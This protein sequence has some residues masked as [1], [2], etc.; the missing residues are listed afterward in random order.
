MYNESNQQLKFRGNMDISTRASY[1]LQGSLELASAT[2]F[3]VYALHSS[4]QDACYGGRYYSLSNNPPV[5]FDNSFSICPEQLLKYK[6]HST[7][8][9]VPVSKLAAITSAASSLHFAIRS[10]QHFSIAFSSS[11]KPYTKF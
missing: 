9:A 6:K 10:I 7:H 1:F 8:F 2:L 5:T 11:K 3:A 4:R